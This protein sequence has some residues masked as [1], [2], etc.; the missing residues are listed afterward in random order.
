MARNIGRGRRT[1]VL[2]D[3]ENHLHPVRHLGD[4]VVAAH[5]A[6]LWARLGGDDEI[7]WAAGVGDRGIVR[8][9]ARAVMGGLRLRLRKTP[10]GRN[11]ADERLI[12]AADD[13]PASVERVVLVTGDLDLLPAVLSLQD[14]GVEVVV[15]SRPSALSWRLERYADDCLLLDEELAEIA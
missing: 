5:L 3:L 7:V 6:L 8:A 1:A 13:V 2:I 4:E 14:R 15:A 12:L 9:A 10:G 11:S